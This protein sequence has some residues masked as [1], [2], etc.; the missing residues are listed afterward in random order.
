MIPQEAVMRMDFTDTEHL[1]E[2]LAHV[3]VHAVQ[4]GKGA[5]RAELSV[6][7]TGDWTLQFIRFIEGTTTCFGGTHGDRHNFLVPL[8]V[9]GPCRLLGEELT[10]DSIAVYA[11]GAEHADVSSN[12]LSEVVI[13]PPQSLIDGLSERSVEFDLP[14]T[15]AA[16]KPL[17]ADSLRRFR[18][19]LV[20]IGKIPPAMLA[21]TRTA[22]SIADQ[23]EIALASCLASDA[24]AT[25]SGRPPLPRPAVLQHL[26]DIL[27]SQDGQPVYASELAAQV[28]VSYP[29][30]RRIFQ[31]WFGTSPSQYL[32]LKR[33][34]LVRR[35]LLSGD[36]ATV[37]EA[38]MSCGFWE[39]GR[40]AGRYRALF[41]ELPSATIGEAQTTGERAASR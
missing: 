6:C 19:V 17:Q 35:R 32:L 29:T 39:L 18:D 38:A 37:T 11:P 31:D 26:A 2:T 24:D 1:S 22:R 12:G 41:G 16:L 14:R 36:Y 23:L 4:L 25:V 30:L 40:F 27:R 7:Q 8:D 13:T 10:G 33:L 9:R 21:D 20:Q 34:Y 5:F 3:D 15:G 28:S